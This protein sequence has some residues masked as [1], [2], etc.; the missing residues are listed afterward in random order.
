MNI[1]LLIATLSEVGYMVTMAAVFSGI[2]LAAMH[3][4]KKICNNFLIGK[5]Q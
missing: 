2:L 3:Q 5:A 1:N 4:I